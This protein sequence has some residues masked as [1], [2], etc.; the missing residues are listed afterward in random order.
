MRRFVFGGHAELAID[1]HCAEDLPFEASFLLCIAD[2]DAFASEKFLRIPESAVAF[3]PEL[4]HR[5]QVAVTR[6]ALGEMLFF[7]EL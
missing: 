5:L 1:I 4:A 3:L 7:Y 6:C 2:G